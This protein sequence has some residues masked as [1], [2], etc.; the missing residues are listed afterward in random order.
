MRISSLHFHKAFPFCGLARK[1]SVQVRRVVFQKVSELHHAAVELRYSI[2]VYQQHLDGLLLLRGISSFLCSSLS[3]FNRSLLSNINW[4]HTYLDLVNPDSRP[5][6]KLN[7]FQS[8]R[9]NQACLSQKTLL[10][11][12]TTTCKVFRNHSFQEIGNYSLIIRGRDVS[13]CTQIE[14]NYIEIFKH[15]FFSR[16]T[17][18]KIV[19]L[20]EQN[21]CYFGFSTVVVFQ[22]KAG[23]QR[24]WICLLFLKQQLWDALVMTLNCIQLL[25]APPGGCWYPSPNKVEGLRREGHPA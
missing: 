9:T 18:S 8:T 15:Y 7:T 1:S 25:P 12:S 20:I 4:W 2:T 14:E 11:V 3:Y 10:S 13:P 19:D 23:G 24:S 5:S 17:M 6:K 16:K 21:H 22:E